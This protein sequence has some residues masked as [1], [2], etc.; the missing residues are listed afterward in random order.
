M[1]VETFT[2]FPGFKSALRSN[3]SILARESASRAVNNVVHA[4]LY[5]EHKRTVR[6]RASFPAAN[7]VI[8]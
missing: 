5:A 7:V 4:I 6:V 1:P 8:D 2:V 3:V